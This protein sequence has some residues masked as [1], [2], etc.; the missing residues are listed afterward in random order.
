M[1]KRERGS[2]IIFSMI[3]RLLE[4]ISSREEEKGTEILEE[5][6]KIFKKWGWGRIS[7]F[8]ELYTFLTYAVP[9]AGALGSVAR[10]S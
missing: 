2:N 3:S 5:K 4:R 8:M 10:G 1:E 9:P 6:I 7:R